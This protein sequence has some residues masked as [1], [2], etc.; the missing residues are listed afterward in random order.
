MSCSSRV[1][2]VRSARLSARS[3]RS[4]VPRKVIG[5]AGG[6]EKCKRLV[7]RYGFDVAID[8]RG[9]SVDQLTAELAA[10]APEG[11][12][13]IFEYVGG[14]I[15]DAGLNALAMRARSGCAA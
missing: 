6:P 4:R 2:R 5:I 3:P 13:V 9:K 12:N 11:V 15:L 1:R 10:A 7:E 8:Y 14:D